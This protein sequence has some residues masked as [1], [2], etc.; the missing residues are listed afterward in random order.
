[1]RRSA[2]KPSFGAD[3]FIYS[4][5]CLTAPLSKLEFKYAYSLKWVHVLT[6][7]FVCTH[8]SVYLVLTY[9]FA[10]TYWSE[11]VVF[12]LLLLLSKSP[13]GAAL[14]REYWV[15]CVA[16]WGLKQSGLCHILWHSPH[17]Y[18]ARVSRKR[19]YTLRILVDLESETTWANEIAISEDAQFISSTL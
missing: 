17:L 12:I 4:H 3:R 13:V 18:D 1:M 2:S 19:A 6:K 8:E 9:V 10:C 5:I 11:Y 16:I 7:V 14:L 15:C